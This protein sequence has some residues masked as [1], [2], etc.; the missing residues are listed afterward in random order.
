MK[1]VGNSITNT[2]AITELIWTAAG[3]PGLLVWLVNL[4]RATSSYRSVARLGNKATRILGGTLFRLALGGTMAEAIFVFWGLFGMTQPQTSQH[5][6][7]L[8]W[9]F[10]CGIVLLSAITAY[11]GYDIRRAT[12]IVWN[13]ASH[14]PQSAATPDTP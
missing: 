9:A 14:P 4:Q 3:V 1:Q 7:P 5:I 8:A 2:I 13:L 6:S 10:T 11:I 12:S